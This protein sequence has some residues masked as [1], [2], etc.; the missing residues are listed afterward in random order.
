MQQ[1]KDWLE[2]LMAAVEQWLRGEPETGAN[3]RAGP[4]GPPPALGSA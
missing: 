2:E 3:S 4:S 1:L